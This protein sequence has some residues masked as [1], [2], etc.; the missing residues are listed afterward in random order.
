MTMIATRSDLQEAIVLV[1]QAQRRLCS[2]PDCNEGCQTTGEVA[3]VVGRLIKRALATTG[4]A[5][6]PLLRDAARVLRS[7]ILAFKDQTIASA[8]ALAPCVGS[9]YL[10][11]AA[12]ESIQADRRRRRRNKS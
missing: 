8:C 1:T 12:L 6:V 7:A 11:T 5:A 10:L 3:G 2:C 4:R 9:E